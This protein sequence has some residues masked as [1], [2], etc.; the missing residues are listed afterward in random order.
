MYFGEGTTHLIGCVKDVLIEFCGDEFEKKGIS[1]LVGGLSD[2]GA[3]MAASSSCCKRPTVSVGDPL[4]P[5]TI[6]SCSLVV[7]E[8]DLGQMYHDW[9]S[10]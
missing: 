9:R 2:N 5:S 7:F 3:S 10:M 6:G 1:N 8:R 4:G